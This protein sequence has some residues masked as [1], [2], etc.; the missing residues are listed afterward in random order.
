MTISET[1]SYVVSQDDY[2]EGVGWI[3]SRKTKKHQKNSSIQILSRSIKKTSSYKPRP[4][5]ERHIKKML[6]ESDHPHLK[7]MIAQFG[8][9]K[10]RGNPR[11][12]H[13]QLSTK[14]S[15]NPGSK[16]AQKQSGRCWIFGTLN[17]MRQYVPEEFGKDFQYSQNHVAYYDKL[18]RTNAFLEKM[19]ELSKEPVEGQKVLNHI[20]YFF[21]D[22]GEVEFVRNV[23]LKHGLV[24][25]YAFTETKFS[26]NSG[27]YNQLIK[28]RIREIGGLLHIKA[29]QGASTEELQEIKL[30][31]IDEVTNILQSYLGKPVDKF[32]WKKQDESIV[33]VTPLEFYEMGGCDLKEFVHLTNLPYL[34][35]NVSVEVP[36]VCNV[37]GAECLSSFNISV[38]ALKNA[39]RRSIQDGKSV[40]F[41]A[42]VKCLDKSKNVWSLDSD[43]TKKI[44]GIDENLRLNKGD[45]LRYRVDVIAHLMNMVG[46]DDEDHWR[47]G[48]PR[49]EDVPETMG[50]LWEI[51]NSWKDHEKLYATGPWMDEYLYA[52]FVHKNYLTKEQKEAIENSDKQIMSL[53]AWDPFGRV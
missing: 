49:T 53:D 32:L 25:D 20:E 14:Y 44:F 28:Q 2:L 6:E 13:S 40:T 18:E 3:S 34:P 24:P 11:I 27:G 22:G 10:I 17:M 33:Y 45:R 50:E 42:E 30:Q 9:D 21:D 31:A 46:C 12:N 5:T 52:I 37:V 47:Y 1:R 7:R 4:L 8:I 35:E 23:I 16:T 43:A 19:I 38:K 29:C 48:G 36:D 41:S 51:E 26:G 39:M 15:I